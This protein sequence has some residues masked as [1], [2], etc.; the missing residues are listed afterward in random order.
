MSNGTKAFFAGVG[1]MTTI[2]FTVWLFVSVI[3]KVCA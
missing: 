2:I 1:I 3:H